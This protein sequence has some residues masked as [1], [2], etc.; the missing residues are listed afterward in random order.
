MLSLGERFVCP[1]HYDAYEDGPAIAAQVVRFLDRAEG[2]VSAA[3]ESG[4]TTD[5]L[6][7]RFEAAWWSAIAEEAP[8]FGPDEKKLLALDVELNAQGLAFAANA[9]RAETA[10]VARRT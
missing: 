7:A 6:Q 1:T 8:H 9:M 4:E 5:V 3:S 2:W 10:A